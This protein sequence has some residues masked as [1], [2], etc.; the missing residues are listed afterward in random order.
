MESCSRPN[1][2]CHNGLRQITTAYE[3]GAVILSSLL[4]PKRLRHFG[5]EGLKRKKASWSPA[6]CLCTLR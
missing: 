2:Y 1:P 3:Q 4:M 5:H 6:R